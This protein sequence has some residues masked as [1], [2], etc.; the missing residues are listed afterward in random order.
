MESGD[1]KMGL[2]CVLPPTHAYTQHA[3]TQTRAH[4]H[5]HTRARAPPMYCIGRTRCVAFRCVLLRSV[6]F[7]CVP[8]RCVPLRCRPWKRP[9][10]MAKALWLTIP[11]GQDAEVPV[12]RHAWGSSTGTPV[13]IQH[14]VDTTQPCDF[15][16]H[17]ESHFACLGMHSLW[18]LCV[19]TGTG[20]P[21]L[22]TSTLPS[23]SECR[24]A[25]FG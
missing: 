6:A 18:E 19:H 14:A 7:C 11:T 2:V 21:G 24:A 15:D 20:G 1:N 16:L 23:R 5:S 10:A 17:T 4:T 8:L 9:F 12:R 22:R 3:Y 25:A 13:L